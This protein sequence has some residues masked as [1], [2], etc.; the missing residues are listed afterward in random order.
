M[1]Y[2]VR[3]EANL[4]LIDDLQAYLDGFYDLVEEQARAAIKR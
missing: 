1:P 2:N 4:G 3:W